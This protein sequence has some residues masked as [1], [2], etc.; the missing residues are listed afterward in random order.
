MYRNEKTAYSFYRI[1]GLSGLF[2]YDIFSCLV[3][4]SI[5]FKMSSSTQSVYLPCWMSEFFNLTRL[6]K[7]TLISD[8][9]KYKYL[10][11]FIISASLQ[12]YYIFIQKRIAKVQRVNMQIS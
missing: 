8:S 3:G 12:F 6:C 11:C 1:N 2:P 10:F 9:F 5:T 7:T 4:E